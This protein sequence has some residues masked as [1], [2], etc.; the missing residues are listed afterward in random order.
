[1]SSRSS[2]RYLP[3]LSEARGLEFPSRSR[4]AVTDRDHRR[5]EHM[6]RASPQY[7]R[8][9][10]RRRSA[11]DGASTLYG[12]RGEHDDTSGAFSCGAPRRW[13]RA[14]SRHRRPSA[15]TR[16]LLRDRA[17]RGQHRAAPA[18]VGVPATTPRL[19]RDVP[20][21]G[22]L[23]ATQERVDEATTPPRR[24]ARRAPAP[25]QL[26][27]EQHRRAAARR[28]CRSAGHVRAAAARSFA[29]PRRARVRARD[30]PGVVES[31]GRP[32]LAILAPGRARA[33]LHPSQSFV[34]RAISSL[35]VVSFG[36]GT[37]STH[38]ALDDLA[39]EGKHG[40]GPARETGPD[41]PACPRGGR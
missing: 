2:S 28:A 5:L 4:R 24:A 32:P 17:C 30:L 18:L 11:S 22:H 9:R 19:R 37:T 8:F 15:R 31:A 26:L 12:L 23:F 34:R 36:C 20:L 38:R 3:S 7:L 41:P 33:P 27:L 16:A 39:R 21:L 35:V 40:V 13:T 6:H 14:R 1:M 25:A 10:A 29:L